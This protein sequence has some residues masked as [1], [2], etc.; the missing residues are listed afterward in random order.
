MARCRRCCVG[1]WR[2]TVVPE[3]HRGPAP[4]VKSLPNSASIVS[5]W[6]R[7]GMGALRSDR[8][9]ACSECGAGIDVYGGGEVGAMCGREGASGRFGTWKSETPLIPN[10]HVS[11][12][13]TKRKHSRIT[14]KT[15]G[16]FIKLHVQPL[17]TSLPTKPSSFTQERLVRIPGATG[18]F[19]NND[20]YLKSNRRNMRNGYSKQLESYFRCNE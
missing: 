14:Q 10:R 3:S 20:R 16:I 19:G 15:P 8:R 12:K 13:T 2:Q 5:R 6:N 11:T 4:P 9:S 7:A 1:P 17:P 18:V